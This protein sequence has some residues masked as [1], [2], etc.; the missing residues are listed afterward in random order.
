MNVN[1][2]SLHAIYN[3][4]VKT[5]PPSICIGTLSTCIPIVLAIYLPIYLS[6]IEWLPSNCQSSGHSD[7]LEWV[8]H[9]AKKKIIVFREHQVETNRVGRSGFSFY[10]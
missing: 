6:N 9:K 7:W 2:A 4:V 10:F 3:L 8:R 5:R 1:M